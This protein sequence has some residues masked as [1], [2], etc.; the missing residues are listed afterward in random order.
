MPSKTKYVVTSMIE[1]YGGDLWIFNITDGFPSL[2]IDTISS[3][4]SSGVY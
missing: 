1:K 4:N 3:I 2:S